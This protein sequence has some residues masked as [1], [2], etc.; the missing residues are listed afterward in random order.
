MLN[1]RS[2]TNKYTRNLGVRLRTF[3]VI[4]LQ[5]RGGIIEWVP[6]VSTMGEC[7]S[8]GTSCTKPSEYETIRQQFKN[9]VSCCIYFHLIIFLL[10]L[11]PRRSWI[12][13]ISLRTFIRWKWANFCEA[14]AQ[15]RR[16]TIK[17]RE[18]TQ[19]QP[20]SCLQLVLLLDLAIDTLATFWLINPPANSCT[21]T[22]VFCSTLEK[23]W[24]FRR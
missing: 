22:F 7:I 8:Q 6:N 18:A 15:V 17:F 12:L 23:N 21:S 11:M 13:I 14:R 9:A 19:P 5:E 2:K 1:M 4:P 20:H 24:M 16:L 10:S 3:C